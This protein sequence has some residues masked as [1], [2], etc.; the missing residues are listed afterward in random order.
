MVKEWQP[1]VVFTVH[2]APLV[3]YTGKAP[4]VFWIDSTSYGRAQFWDLYGKPANTVA[5][6][7]EKRGFANTARVITHSEWSRRII[8]E[9]YKFPDENIDVFPIP[10]ALPSGVVPAKVELPAWKSLDQPLRLLLVGR[11]FVRKGIGTA[12][13]VVEKLNE[14]GVPAS[15]TICGGS[16]EDSG[17]VKYAGPFRKNDPAQ[18]AAYV[19]LYRQAHLLIHPAK[20]EAAGIVPAEAAAFGTPT[21]TNDVGGLG[22][23][24][25]HGE[26]GIVLPAGSS[27]DEYVHAIRQL[28][29]D[30]AAYYQMCQR[31]R[32]RFERELTWETSTELVA[33][34]VRKTADQVH[35]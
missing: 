10:S 31:A 16:G 30:P 13:E 17:Y 28:I 6:W 29:Q 34:T 7:Q 15:L 23:T 22:T 4:C 27:A 5:F 14:A 21:I 26:S 32:D 35:Q 24:V 9:V 11:D 8:S 25:A 1:D 33:E 12:I 19:D 3:F 2:L 18:L 20:F